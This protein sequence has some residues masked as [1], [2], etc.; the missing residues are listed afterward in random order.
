MF[1]NN[2][3]QKDSKLVKTA[4]KNLDQFK[5]S[6]QDPEIYDEFDPVINFSVIIAFGDNYL[7]VEVSSIDVNLKVSLNLRGIISREDLKVG[8]DLHETYKIISVGELTL[9]ENIIV[10]YHEML[11]MEMTYCS[12]NG[13][14]IDTKL[15]NFRELEIICSKALN[16]LLCDRIFVTYKDFYTTGELL[17]EC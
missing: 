17:F 6:S 5:F 3:V 7:L 2:K 8:M 4:V 1:I 14:V 13:M 12:S 16:L 11:R 15:Y 10:N 9:H